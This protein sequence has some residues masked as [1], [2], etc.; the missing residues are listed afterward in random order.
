MRMV[1]QRQKER[2]DAVK[3]TTFDGRALAIIRPNGEG[4]IQAREKGRDF[5]QIAESG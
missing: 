5:L 4:A 1:L 2:F 3:H